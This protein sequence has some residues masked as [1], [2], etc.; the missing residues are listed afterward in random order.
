M[1]DAYA[2]RV[3]PAPTPLSRCYPEAIGN[4]DV[5]VRSRRKDGCQHHITESSHDQCQISK[6]C[7]SSYRGRWHRIHGVRG[8]GLVR[9][10]I[11]DFG[12]QS[13]PDSQDRRL[14]IC[15]YDL[16]L[17]GSPAHFDRRVFYKLSTKPV[18]CASMLRHDGISK[19]RTKICSHTS[20]IRDSCP[21]MFSA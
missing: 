13:L 1:Y 10:Q 17:D 21:F 15:V 18:C 7:A 20:L 9:R 14:R 11:S 5:G 16:P 2:V 8:N 4:D 19:L 3:Q 12:R 6:P